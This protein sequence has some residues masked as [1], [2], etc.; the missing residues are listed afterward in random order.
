RRL[1]AFLAAVML[2]RVLGRPAVDLGAPRLGLGERTL[3]LGRQLARRFRG[4]G[5]A[6]LVGCIHGAVTILTAQKRRSF[7][8]C[9][10]Q[11]YAVSAPSP[12]PYR[13]PTLPTPAAA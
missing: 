7:V 1:P 12:S 6:L 13:R 9:R 2:L 10:R 4:A 11:F 5:S 8:P 3:G